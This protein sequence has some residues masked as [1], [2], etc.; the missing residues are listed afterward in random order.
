MIF[1]AQVKKKRLILIGRTGKL[2][3][4]MKKA[5]FGILLVLLSSIAFA[6]PVIISNPNTDVEQNKAVVY[7]IPE[8]YYEYVNSIEFVDGAVKCRVIDVYG[9]KKCY[10]GWYKIYWD[11]NHNCYNGKI[12]LNSNIF[13][14]DN[15]RHELGHIYQHCVLGRDISTEEF[16]NGFKI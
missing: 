10:N 15:L 13:P 5:L 9:Q 16:A 6:Y 14:Y 1:I 12:T 7:A 2:P 11:K 8:K 3:V 4:T